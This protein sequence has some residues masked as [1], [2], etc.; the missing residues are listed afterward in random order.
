MASALPSDQPARTFVTGIDDFATRISDW[1]RRNERLYLVLCTISSLI[2]FGGYSH[3]KQPWYD[4]TLQLT[5]ARQNHIH[6]IWTAVKNGIIAEP[7]FLS[8]VQHFLLRSFGDSMFVMRIPN[9]IGF[10]LGCLCLAALAWRYVPPIFAASVYFVPYTTMMR[11]R[12]EDARPY[13]LM[14]GCAAL[15]LLCWDRIGGPGP[16]RLAW[17]LAFVVSL[18]ALFSTHF[19]S[20]LVLLPLGL[21]ELSRWILNRKVAWLTVACVAVGLLPF[22]AWLPILL[23]V[24]REYMGGYTYH[25]DFQNFFIFYD[26]IATGLP[27]GAFRYFS[28]WM[29]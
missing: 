8:V 27:F 11:W 16:R 25:V 29:A 17:S 22:L 7:P 19:Y 12:A 6:D 14:F 13:G 9:V 24:S 1:L 21:G 20:I 23:S 2:T 18:A 26:S 3:A 15:A 28:G 10:T 5:V 4:E